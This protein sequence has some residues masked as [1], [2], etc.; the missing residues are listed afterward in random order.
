MDTI[1][2]TINGQEIDAPVGATILEVVREQGLDDIPTLCHSPELKPYG[3]CFVC[4]VELEGK[5]NLVPSCATKVA[6]GMKI[7]TRNERVIA[8]RRTA[9]ELLLSNHYA[10]CLSPCLLGCPA[11]VDAQGYIALAAMGEYR[12]AID[13]IRETNPLPAICGRVCVRKCEINCRRKDIDA[14]VAINNVKRFVSDSQGAYDGMPERMPSNGK[15]IGI[16]G[17]GPAGLTAAWFLGKM[18]YDPVL[19]EAHDR[20]GGMLRYGI[21]EYRLPDAVLDKEIEFICRAGA[22][23]KYNTRVGEDI[24]LDELRKKHDAVFIAA[25]AMGG[26]DMGVPGEETTVGVVSGVEFLHEKADSKTPVH[27]TVVVVGGGNTAMDVART[28]WR[29]GAQK[30]IILYRRTKDEMPADKMEIEDCIKEGIEIYEL[31]MPVSIVSENNKLKALRCIRMKLGEPDSSGR[32][33]PVPL[34]GSEFDLPCDMAVSAIGQSPILKGLSGPAVTRWGTII[35]DP[36][37]MATN[38]PGLF[39]GGDVADDG[40]T[41]VIDSIR[42]GQRAAKAIHSYISGEP[43]PAEP[44]GVTKDFWSKP[45]NA[46]LGDI[47]ESPRHEIHELEVEHRRGNFEEVA[48]GFDYEDVAHEANRCLSCGCVR[49]DDCSLRLYAEEYG[50]DMEHYKGYV[51]KHRVDARHPYIVYDPNKCVLCSRCIRTCDRVLPVSALGL[52]NRGFKTEMRPALNEPLAK[53][54]CIS[55]G[56]CVDSCPTGALTV[57]WPFPGRAS[58]DF[59]SIPTFCGFCSV[60]CA[61]TVKKFGDSRYTIASSGRPGDYLCRY[62][63]FGN[64]LFIRSKRLTNPLERIKSKHSDVAF[65]YAYNKT[66]ESMKEIVAKYGPES[67]AVLVSPELTCEELYLAN[68]IARE[69]LKTNNIGSLSL[70]MGSSVAGALDNS[71]GYTASTATR[72]CLREADLIICNNTGTQND[73]LILGVE[74]IDAVKDGA[75]LIV[76]N[77]SVDPLAQLAE[78]N[79]DPM[80]GRSALLWSGVAKLLL[81]AKFPKAESLESVDGS[82]GFVAEL[83]KHSIGDVSSSTGVDGAKIQNAAELLMGARKV[84][85]IHSPDRPYDSAAGDMSALANLVILLRSAGL[86][87]QLLLPSMYSNGAGVEISGADPQFTAGR[88]PVENPVGSKSRTELR[89]LLESGT[90]RGALVI[91]EDPISHDSTASFFRNIEFLAAFDWAVTETVQFADIAFPMG[92]YLEGQ[93]TRVNFEGLVHTYS[94]VLEPPSGIQGWTV[95]YELAS[96]FGAHLPA[97]NI[98]K[99]SAALNRIA[100]TGAKK[101][102]PYYFNTGECH[103]SEICAKLTVSDVATRAA[104]I[105]PPVTVMDKYKR[106]IREVGID[107][108]RVK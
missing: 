44:F 105:P 18:G 96:K 101:L 6:P 95:L 76:C 70:L 74:V 29:L 52:V 90:I 72:G 64:E 80:R 83:S 13:L 45:G 35:S 8:S 21:P 9:F 57:K 36:K 32:R 62:G 40:P 24:T 10:D 17:A 61:I 39:A 16:V 79:L 1:K 5:P 41:V 50:V 89:K 92:T 84:V 73:Q 12:R 88:L 46:E 108:F 20:G 15:T 100:H 48:T 33:R 55:C 78:L 63:R 91:G 2:I 67:V 82:A 99:I 87:A 65:A 11:G 94:P 28:S 59:E 27:G 7:N 14:P 30:V 56:N 75:K 97:K 23:I 71:F 34:E 93:G 69:G 53:T 49:F 3:S 47:P 104:K 19:Y 77:S 37:T 102:A 85:F 103:M 107:N 98:T 58:I 51:R 86:D 25:G 106:T 42:D 68:L 81:D 38:I 26:K 60:G 54:S 31:A 66:I 43:I 22:E 4:V